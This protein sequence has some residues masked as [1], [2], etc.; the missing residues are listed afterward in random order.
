MTSI[1]G[2]AAGIHQHAMWPRA[3]S[4]DPSLP[5]ALAPWRSRPD[6]SRQ[7]PA[8]SRTSHVQRKGGFDWGAEQGQFFDPGNINFNVSLL[9]STGLVSSSGT[10]GSGCRWRRG[11]RQ[12]GGKGVGSA[13]SHIHVRCFKQDRTPSVMFAVGG[14]GATLPRMQ[15]KRSCAARSR[16][17]QDCAEPCRGAPDASRCNATARVRRGPLHSPPAL[18]EKAARRPSRI[19][20]P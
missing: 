15:S 17:L 19:A 2:P 18:Q 10:P 1:A 8:A 5:Q 14:G 11:Q 16:H 9:L 4:I 13:V 12:C 7:P 6:P 3:R 20:G